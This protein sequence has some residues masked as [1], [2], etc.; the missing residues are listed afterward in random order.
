MGLRGLRC[1]SFPQKYLFL[2]LD[3]QFL[4]S[5]AFHITAAIY[6]LNSREM[7]SGLPSI[8]PGYLLGLKEIQTKFNFTVE[9][10]VI[11]NTFI[12]RCEDIGANLFLI[13]EFYYKKRDKKSLFL[14]FYIGTKLTQYCTSLMVY[15]VLLRTGCDDVLQFS[16]LSAG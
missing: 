10:A 7:I 15:G 8:L 3:L 11:N 4:R 5:N 2:L 9:V 1:R 14:L 6:G 16:S 13:P 12:Y